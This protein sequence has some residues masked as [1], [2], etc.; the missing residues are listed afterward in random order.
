M[1]RPSKGPRVERNRRGVYEI[2]WTE[3]GRSKRLSTRTSNLQEAQQVF[4][5]WLTEYEQE[6]GQTAPTIDLILDQYLDERVVDRAAAQQRQ[7]DAA[8]A[9]REG[10]GDYR[11]TEVT[12]EVVKRYQR[13]RLD[14]T[15]RGKRRRCQSEATLRRELNCLKA[16]L[17]HALKRKRITQ[18]QLPYFELPRSS[19]PA[20]FWLSETETDQLLSYAAT[21]DDGDGRLSRVYRYLVIS[22]ATAA[23]MSAVLNLT[24]HQV[25]LDGGLI[26]FDLSADGQT[27]TGNDTRKRRVPVPIADWLYPI[28]VQMRRERINEYV[29][30]DNRQ[31]RRAMD[32]VC[33][34]A[35]DEFFNPRFRKLTRHALRHTAATHMAR[36]GVNMWQLA[37]VLGDSLAT[38]QRNYLHHCPDHLRSA[39]N[40]RTPQQADIKKA[41]R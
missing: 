41:D 37:G 25:D 29:L 5:G 24:W 17:N 1:A 18:D 27:R 10:L 7:F 22:V 23:R 12:D 6:T 20:E 16:A 15:I 32:K 30:D 13:K 8:K 26:R 11:V 35:A 19:P 2:R 40:F 3:D 4:A 33:A 31:I 9:L 28:L 34:G 39:V 21:V 14:G 38:V 36:A